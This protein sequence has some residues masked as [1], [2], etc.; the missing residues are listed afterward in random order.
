MAPYT[1]VATWLL[2]STLLGVVALLLARVARLRHPSV[3]EAWWSSGAVMVVVVPVM[4]L[5]IPGTPTPPPPLASFVESATVALAGPAYPSALL[6]PSTWLALIWGTGIVL[7]LGWLVAG[8]RRL[9]RLARLSRPIE[10]DPALSTARALVAA[11][12]GVLGRG[13][14]VPVVATADA[15]PFA[16]GWWTVRVVVPT[17]L[18][19]L[20]EPQRAAVYVHELLHAGRFDVQRSYLD[21][22]WRLVWWW[23]P[24]VW[25]ML[26]R[27][28]LARELA[29]DRAVVEATGARRAYVEALLWCGARSV[30]LAL[31]SQVGGS[32]HALVRRVAMLCEE[33]EMTGVRRWITILGLGLAFG[34]ASM[35]IAQHS[36]LRASQVA[37]PSVASSTEPGPLERAAALPTLDAPAPRRTSA[38]TPAWPEGESGYLLRVH[39]IVD[40]SGQVA[41]ARVVGVPA[42]DVLPSTPRLASAVEA[43]L[44]AVR[45]WQFEAPVVAPMLLAT[46]VA[47][48]EPRR[49]STPLRRAASGPAPLRV[50]GGIAPPRKILDV[51][52]EY[53]QVA[54]DAK[55]QGVVI[56]ECTLDTEGVVTDTRVVRSIPLLDQAALDAVRQWRYTP[57][58]VNGEAVP[59]IVTVTVNFT[60]SR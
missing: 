1:F 16:F 42:P 23:Q 24:A 13:I 54:F 4:P 31:T 38:V 18:L 35:V 34:G 58:W 43:A 6:S 44:D 14:V 30:R 53:P 2:Q 29:V 60:L 36:P 7:R 27:L 52:P 8:Q 21:E 15:G 45:Q 39:V 56:I 51:K 9:Q 25:W 59:V 40:A 10:D 41:E 49:V 20:P 22:F 46:D 28:R 19:T 3:L 11:Q 26:S 57:T 50:G 48:G 47:V 37:S 55:V 33:V 5:V 12:P 32:R 17:S